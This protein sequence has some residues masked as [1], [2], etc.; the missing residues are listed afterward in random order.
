MTCRMCG[1]PASFV[2]ITLDTARQ[3]PMCAMCVSRH[4]TRALDACRAHDPRIA[5]PTPPPARLN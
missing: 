4:I 2:Y 3:I 1:A 5:V